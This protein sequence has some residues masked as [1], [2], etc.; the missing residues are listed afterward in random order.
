MQLNTNMLVQMGKTSQVFFNQ[1][2]FAN[3]CQ[4]TADITLTLKL[5]FIGP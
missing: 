1:I 2:H 5:F 4:L 3:I